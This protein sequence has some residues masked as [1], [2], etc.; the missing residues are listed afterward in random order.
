MTAQPA[1]TAAF[2]TSPG[3]GS[4][5]AD[6]GLRVNWIS[7][8]GC[9]ICRPVGSLDAISVSLLREVTADIPVG[10]SL[11]LDLSALTFIDSAGREAL[12][13]AAR[14]VRSLGGAANAA[15]PRPLVRRVLVHT[16]FD[17]A[18]PVFATAN[19]AVSAHKGELVAAE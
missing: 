14:W 16:G 13:A 2:T 15:A 8:D 9:L 5:R 12:L 1:G 6:R 17:R 19:Q 18:V 7:I 10:A 4:S 11:V 3:A